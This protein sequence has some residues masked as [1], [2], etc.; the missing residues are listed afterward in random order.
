MINPA[1]EIERLLQFG[2]KY[3]PM[4]ISKM[5]FQL[6]LEFVRQFP[7]YI[8][9]SNADL[10]IVGGSILALSLDSTVI[11]RPNGKNVL[12]LR[13]PIFQIGPRLVWITL[14]VQKD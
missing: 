12:V 14:R 9:G 3:E 7:H 4:A 6:L 10:P 2:E 5:T 11:A 1:Y 8:C 13:K